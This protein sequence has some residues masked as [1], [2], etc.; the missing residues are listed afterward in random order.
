MLVSF[1]C[2]YPTKNKS[3]TSKFCGKNVIDSDSRI[4]LTLDLHIISNLI[5][6]KTSKNRKLSL[7]FIL[8]FPRTNTSYESQL[9]ESHESP[10]LQSSADNFKLIP[11]ELRLVTDCNQKS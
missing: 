11:L 1:K 6:K 3:F 4:N 2:D 7:G 8:F 9:H 10:I 5:F